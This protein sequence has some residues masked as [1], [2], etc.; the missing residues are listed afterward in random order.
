M[1]NLYLDFTEVGMS[2]LFHIFYPNIDARIDKPRKSFTVPEVMEN[3]MAWLDEGGIDYQLVNLTVRALF[4]SAD[5]FEIRKDAT[6]F[7]ASITVNDLM[8]AIAATPS[9]QEFEREL[10]DISDQSE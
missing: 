4:K 6:S 1:P 3:L 5:K 7:N 8:S 10:I 2:G 9:E